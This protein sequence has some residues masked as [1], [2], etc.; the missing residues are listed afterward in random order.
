MNFD[1]F[2]SHESDHAPLAVRMRPTDILE[3]LGQEHLT[4]K[5]MPLDRL[6]SSNAPGQKNS[7]I[8]W[9]PPGT[10]KTTIAKLS[11]NILGSEY[12]ELSATN[13]GVAEIRKVIES[14]KITRKMYNKDTILFLDEIHR[15]SKSQ[16]DAL[17]PAVENGWLILIGAT[18]E[19]P[20]FSV[21]SPLLSR[22]I[23]LTLNILDDEPLK[24]LLFKAISSPNGLKGSVTI[25]EDSIPYLLRYANGDARRLLTALEASAS[26][27]IMSQNGIRSL[28]GES[29]D[30]NR[31]VITKSIINNAVSSIGVSYDRDG[32]QHYDV[33]SAYIKSMRG[34]DVDAALHYLSK[35]LVAGEDPRYIARRLVVH[36]S[37]DV[38]LADPTALLSA[39]AASHAVALVGMPE[40]RLALA[41]ATIHIALAPKSNSVYKAITMAIEDIADGLPSEI[42][43]HIRDGHYAGA[44]KLGH[45]VEYKYPH[46]YPNSIVK[47]QYLP[48]SFKSR[49]YFYPSASEG[50]SIW[51]ERDE[52]NRLILNREV[53][54]VTSTDI[55]NS[56]DLERNNENEEEV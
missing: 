11:A 35:M 49:R 6:M 31:P 14:A 53:N 23:M 9:G 4:G 54:T 30:V 32:Q 24:T 56:I 38:G 12:I 28:D 21:I 8:L 55:Q 16:Q 43:K 29:N 45:G 51:R 47:Q 40:A 13:S 27:A 10:G 37:E 46:D 2:D 1:L 33:T 42:P 26:A 15:Y 48:D 5:G 36:A 25:E 3:V 22:S 7:I 34:S 50:E 41:Q 20:S 44:A 18:T 39:I 19:N 17:L 52:N